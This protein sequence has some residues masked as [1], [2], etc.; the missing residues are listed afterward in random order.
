M[1]KC[2]ELTFTQC[3]QLINNDYDLRDFI[4]SIEN[5]PDFIKEMGAIDSIAELQ[6]IQGGG[7]ASGAYMPAVT[8]HTAIEIMSNHSIEVF[9]YIESKFGEI[10]QPQK[11]T[12]WSGLAVFYLSLAVEEFANSFN[13]DDVNWD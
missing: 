9:D 8:Y 2:I 5:Q 13:L 3:K 6:A 7:C 12:S 4:E 1:D 10:P 11:I